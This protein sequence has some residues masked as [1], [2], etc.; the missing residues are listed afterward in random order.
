MNGQPSWGDL[1]P[2]QY[3]YATALFDP[4]VSFFAFSQ[5]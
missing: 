4:S 2:D 5:V 3:I 1:I